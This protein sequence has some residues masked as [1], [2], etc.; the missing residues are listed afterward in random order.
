MWNRA[1]AGEP[2]EYLGPV[3]IFPCDDL[4]PHDTEHGLGCWC[5]PFEDDGMIVHN[6]MDGREAFERGERRVS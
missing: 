2:E 6:S 1:V 3:H 4:R 5:R